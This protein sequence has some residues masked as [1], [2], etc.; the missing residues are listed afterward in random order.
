[1]DGEADGDLLEGGAGDDALIGGA[2]DDVLHGD[3]GGDRL[4]GGAGDDV[5]EGGT[6]TISW[7]AA[8]TLTSTCSRAT[9]GTTFSPGNDRAPKTRWIS[10]P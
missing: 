6:G 8:P 2:G 5:L 9:G 10:P 4:E 7:T 3:E 1:M